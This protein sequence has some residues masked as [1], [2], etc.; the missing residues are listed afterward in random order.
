M[1][2][3]NYTRS[4]KQIGRTLTSTYNSNNLIIQKQKVTKDQRKSHPP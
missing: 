1:K 4:L 2:I 3:F